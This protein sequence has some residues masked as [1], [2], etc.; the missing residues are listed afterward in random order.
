MVPLENWPDIQK[1][2]GLLLLCVRGERIHI[3][4]LI[5]K[6]CDL[7]MLAPQAQLGRLGRRL[8]PF[9]SGWQLPDHDATLYQTGRK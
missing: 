9:K 6:V 7:D 4:I 5:A 3:V 1:V 2:P 8:V